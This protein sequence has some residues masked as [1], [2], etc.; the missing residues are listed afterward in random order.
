M[1]ALF[2]PFCPGPALAHA[3]ACLAVA[4]EFASRGHEASMAYGGTR[5]DLIR[6]EGVRVVPA[7]EIPLE[8]AGSHD[9]VDRFYPDVASVIRAIEGDRALIEAEAPD[10]VV[11]DL[12]FPST[13][14]AE[15]A[16]VPVVT[17]NHFLPFTGYTETSSWR[18]R[19]GMLRHPLR[20]ATRFGS[21]FE[22]DPFR[23]RVLAARFSE[24]RLELGLQP[25]DRLPMTGPCTAF[26][27]T[28]FLDPP[29]RPLPDGWHFAGPVTWSAAGGAP[30]PDP[31]DRPLVFAT[32]GTLGFRQAI[33][34]VAKGVS[35][36][37]AEVAVATMGAADHDAI[38][39]LGSRIRA[40]D[41]VDT[42]A[43]LAAADLAVVHGGHLT[44]SAA[45][46]AGTPT[47]VIP[48]GRDHWAWA[49]KVTRFGTGISLY[50]PLLPGAIGRAAKKVLSDPGYA[51]RAAA[52]A[53]ALG[54]WKGEQRI[55]DLI[56]RVAADPKLGICGVP[57]P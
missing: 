25:R 31:G 7:D 55:S 43:W 37:G 20:V 24:A 34:E 10:V 28:P 26:T 54:D 52:L 12:R 18:R 46:R 56:E 49:A 36:L 32:Q 14:A 16:G 39:A 22:R 42:D 53:E 13:S 19:L 27:T 29:N 5:P 8:A 11:V 48:D 23:T 30:P 4:E 51:E 47:V 1:K 2:L 15:L 9:R 3:G 40:F 38:R 57:E 17:I 21:L 44:M 41:F 45:A 50:R 33:R 6:G 35:G